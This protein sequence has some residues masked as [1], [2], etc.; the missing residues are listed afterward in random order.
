MDDKKTLT[1]T[2]QELA[3]LIETV[4]QNLSKL[5]QLEELPNVQYDSPNAREAYRDVANGIFEGATVVSAEA[6][7]DCSKIK[8]LFQEAKTDIAKAAALN[9]YKKARAMTH[10]M[11][12]SATKS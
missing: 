6:S 12:I 3:G 9:V 7:L 4:L 5:N 10:D 11:Q 8:R 2:P 1:T